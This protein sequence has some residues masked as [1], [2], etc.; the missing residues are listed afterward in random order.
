MCRRPSGSRWGPT[1][2]LHR[3]STFTDITDSL[4]H[5]TVSYKVLA[6]K[7]R[8][9]RFDDVIGQRGV[10]QTLRNAIARRAHRPVVRVRRPARRRQDH[11]GAHPGARPELRT[12]PDRRS[13]RRLRRLR[14]DRRQ[15]RDMDVLEIDAATHTAGRQGPRGHHRRPRHGAGPRPLQDLHH[16]RSPPPLA[17]GLRR[18]AQ[19]D[20]GA[21]AARRLHDGDDRDR[22]GAA[23]DPVAV[24]GLRAEDDR[25]EADRRSAAR[26]RRRRADRRSTTRR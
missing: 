16:R 23:D 24:A 18:A 7:W 20:R 8:P 13:L 6:R 22:Q 5:R 4:Q 14:R 3:P 19:V 11:D 21:A 10:T 26:D 17:A 25:R 2:G 15:G 9:Q 12:G 1:G